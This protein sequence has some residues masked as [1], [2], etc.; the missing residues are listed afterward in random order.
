[1]NN[2]PSSTSRRRRWRSAYKSPHAVFSTLAAAQILFW[3]A[4]CGR[5]AMKALLP[6]SSS[7][8]HRNHFC[9]VRSSH[10]LLCILHRPSCS[11][12]RCTAALEGYLEQRSPRY[13][14]GWMGS[15]M[16][17]HLYVMRCPDAI[18][19]WLHSGT[20][21]CSLAPLSTDLYLKADNDE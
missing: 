10:Y 16:S 19:C 5:V 13:V 11:N 3:P 6:S 1:M 15:W 8:H 14:D 7:C 21:P 2:Q 17:E 20:I 4:D 18:T 9:P 12:C